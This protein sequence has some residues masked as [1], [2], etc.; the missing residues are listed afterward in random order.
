MRTL[1]RRAVQH[2]AGAERLVL[3]GRFGSLGRVR[4]LTR[5]GSQRGTPVDR[6]YIERYL[7]AHRSCVRGRVLEVKDD[8]Y[9][10]RL[11]ADAV[12]IV[13]NDPSNARATIVGDLCN[14]LTLPPMSYDAAVVTQTLQFLSDPATAVANLVRGL[15]PGGALLLTVPCL[16]RVDGTHDLWRWTPAGMRQLLSTVVPEGSVTEVSG[17]GNGLAGRAFLFGLAAEDL[18]DG[19]LAQQDDERPLVVGACVRRPG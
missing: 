17:L 15:R 18:R 4:A 16:S 6:W 8:R 5:W 14:P 11:G 19:T 1:A 13:D 2:V 12:E 10:S 3:M 7:Q 9:A